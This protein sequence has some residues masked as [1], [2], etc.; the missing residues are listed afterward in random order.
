MPVPVRV[1]V[2]VSARTT[3]SLTVTLPTC[4]GGHT[5]V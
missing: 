3:D 2:A 1:S 5:E 4:V